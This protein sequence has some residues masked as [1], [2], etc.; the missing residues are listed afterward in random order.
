MVRRPP[1]C[2]VLRDD[3]VRVAVVDQGTNT[4]RLFLAGVE[5][6]RVVA[7]RRFTTVT[8]LGQ[9]VDEHRRLDPAAAQRVR[10][11]IAGFATQIA[12]FAPSRSLLIA[13]SVLRDARGRS[14]FLDELRG[15]FDLPWSVL[16]G[17][18]EA[19]LAFRGGVS[20]AP[21]LRG[22]LVVVDIGGGST[23]FAVGEA[24]G[25]AP[26]GPVASTSGQCGSPSASCATTRRPV[27]S[28]RRP[29]RS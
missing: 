22:A 26:C 9:G 7:G 6:G 21:D 25:S 20:G 3:A 19:A 16:D 28:G 11:V 18:Q 14:Q 8:R 29:R 13:T 10:T 15:R 12:A 5:S 24:T 1:L 23:E 2:C 17:D 27:S 4:T